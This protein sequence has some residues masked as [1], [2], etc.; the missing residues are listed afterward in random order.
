MKVTVVTSVFLESC[1]FPWSEAGLIMKAE[2]RGKLQLISR[3]GDRTTKTELEKHIL[4][5]FILEGYRSTHLIVP[6]VI[7]P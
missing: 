5:P 2:G 3:V 1:S 7:V 6:G 4:E